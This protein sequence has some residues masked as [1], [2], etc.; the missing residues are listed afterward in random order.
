M[1][2]QVFQRVLQTLSERRDA[3]ER[4]EQRRLREVLDKC[5]EIGT[6]MEERR[7][8]VLSSVYSAFSAPAADDLPERVE[9]WN[10]QIRT[11]LTGNGFPEDWSP[12]SSAHS[13]KIPALPA[14][15]GKPYAAVP[16]PCM[17]SWSKAKAVLMKTRLLN[18]ST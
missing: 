8:A 9:A 11:L 12:Y 10:A 6:L 14:A 5:P 15:A 2:E 7:N 3:N 17:H 1:N 18:V 16:K 4:E 13:V